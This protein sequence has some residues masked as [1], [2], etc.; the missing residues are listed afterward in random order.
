MAQQ[1]PYRTLGV[2]P[3]VSDDELRTAYRHLAQLHHPDHNN[4]SP[5]S[6]K[7]FEEVQDA[8]AQVRRLRESSPRA[9][10]T[11]PRVKAD[12]DVEARLADL[13]RELREAQAARERAR[14]AAAEA[15]AAT[16]KRPSDEELGYVRT[17][18]TLGK[19]LDDARAELADRLSGAREH[20][21]AKRITDLIDELASKARRDPRDD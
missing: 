8:Y 3:N 21:I 16:A 13:E 15:A 9:D 11:P 10:E 18:D 17:D 14:R 19:L 2:S 5:E 7:R 12:P 1:D 6:A 4:G 20:S